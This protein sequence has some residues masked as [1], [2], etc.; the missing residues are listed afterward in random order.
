MAPVFI[1]YSRADAQFIDDLVPLLE[2]AYGRG[3]AFYDEQ[4]PGGAKWWE[5]ILKEIAA[6]DL[7]IYLCSNDSLR[8]PYCQSELREAVQQKKQILPVIVRPKTKYPFPGV[9]YGS[10]IPDDVAVILRDTNSINLSRGFRDRDQGAK[11][12]FKLLGAINKALEAAKATAPQVVTSPPTP[13]PPVGDKRKRHWLNEPRAIIAAAVITGV[14]VIAAAIVPSLLNAQNGVLPST[15][16]PT[17]TIS[18]MTEQVAAAASLPSE[19]PIPTVS[20]SPTNELTSTWSPSNTPTSTVTPS[21]T[22][23]PTATSS[24]T[25]TAFSPSTPSITP[26]YVA[27]AQVLQVLETQTS[28]AM[29]ADQA[30]IVSANLTMNTLSWTPTTTITPSQNVTSTLTPQPIEFPT[31]T[32]VLTQ[33]P[34]EQVSNAT[35]LAVNVNFANLRSGPGT[36]YSI[37]GTVTLGSAF[38]IIA[39]TADSSWFLISVS[40]SLAWISV[41]V[42]NLPSTEIQIALTMPAEP[43]GLTPTEENSGDLLDAYCFAEIGETVYLRGQSFAPI[44]TAPF[45]LVDVTRLPVD[46]PVIVLYRIEANDPNHYSC[47]CWLQVQTSTGLIGYVGD[48][49]VNSRNHPPN[50]GSRIVNGEHCN[51]G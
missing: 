7:F 19:P 35:S 31:H 33:T 18:P 40:N 42:V 4:I 34:T 49:Y 5:M 28:V 41:S 22:T 47:E 44:V 38:P 29:L 48:N 8:S 43:I 39:R 20:P 23:E 26:N 13:Q 11:A 17:S 1:S 6:C 2:E 10:E 37:V 14:F 46:T 24:P 51:I 30:T 12:S 16:S 9:D 36:N 50:V 32:I 27:T 15:D 45:S 21:E 25:V 3:F